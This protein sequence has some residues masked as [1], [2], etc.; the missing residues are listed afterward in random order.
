MKYLKIFKNWRIT[1]LC[2]IFIAAMFLIAGEGNNVT[3]III[4]KLVGFALVTFGYKVAKDW[5][6]K[7]LLDELKEVFK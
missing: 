4:A 1:A 7:G 5:R 2:V 6:E 3:L